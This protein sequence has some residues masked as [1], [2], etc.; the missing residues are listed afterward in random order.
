MDSVL[1]RVMDDWD[2]KP[3]VMPFEFGCILMG[4]G[5]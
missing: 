3:N 5:L 4:T 2:P 1:L